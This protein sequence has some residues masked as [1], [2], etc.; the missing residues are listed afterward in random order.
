ML[1]F[2]LRITHVPVIFI[3]ALLLLSCGQSRKEVAQLLAQAEAAPAQHPDSALHYLN[4]IQHPTRLNK[5]QHAHYHLLR[6]QAKDKAGQDISADTIICEAKNY[7]RQRKDFEKATLAAFYEGLVFAAGK[8]DRRAIKIFLEAEN[9]AEHISDT[10][11]KGLIQHN[12]GYLY[13]NNR[14]DY[15]QAAVRFKQAFGYFQAGNHYTYS[16][17]ALNLLGACFLLQGQADSALFYQQQGLDMAVAH[18]DTAAQAK[19]LQNM[20][21]TYREMGNKQQAKAHAL[22]AADLH[23]TVGETVNTCLNLAHIYY[24]C[25]QYDSAAF[26]LN[27]ILQMPEKK[28]LVSAYA[29]LTKIEK[30][31]HNYPKA[32][33]YHEKYTGQIFEIYKEKEAKSIAGIQEKHA[34]EIVKNKNQQLLIHRLGIF[35]IASLVVLFLLGVLFFL[36]HRNSRQKITLLKVK[37][38]RAKLYAQRVDV[39]K[40]TNLLERN[41]KKA[42]KEQYAGILP[43]IKQ[44]NY[45]AAE[46]LTWDAL[47]D[48]INEQYAGVLGR[49]KEELPPLTEPEFKI[50]CLVYA[51]FSNAEIATMLHFMLNTVKTRKV[52]IGRKLGMPKN[53]HLREF[54]I[55]KF[56]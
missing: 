39:L 22:Q 33:G 24:D 49:L 43:K 56:H 38:E 12:I 26:Y 3:V 50:C 31:N 5:A 17:E 15:D 1:I 23:A 53:G 13:Y 18:A 10:K 9:M 28:Q 19:V 45:N 40:Q 7:Y 54:L 44:I 52:A 6:V 27:K 34:L 36:Y 37:E 55:E 30:A 41:L 29:L 46:E 32:L 4:A 20:S 16:I 11:R 21:V 35:I 42:E 2:S 48:A 8:D 25:A 51:G 14:T 47:Y